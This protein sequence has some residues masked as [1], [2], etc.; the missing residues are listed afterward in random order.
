MVGHVQG[1]WEYIWAAY[2]LTWSGIALFGAS[3]VPPGRLRLAFRELIGGAMLLFVGLMLV[4]LA[5]ATGAPF[6]D[7]AVLTVG[8]LAVGLALLGHSV[9]QVAQ[10]RRKEQ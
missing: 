3:L 2:F 1:G 10:H 8:A 6:V 9:V 4:S 5:G 7:R